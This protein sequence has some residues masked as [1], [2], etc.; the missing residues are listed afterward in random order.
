[1]RF[2]FVAGLCLIASAALAGVDVQQV[3][4]PGMLHGFLFASTSIEPVARLYDLLAAAVRRCA[5]DHPG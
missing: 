5:G 1:M 3:T 4:A 2:F